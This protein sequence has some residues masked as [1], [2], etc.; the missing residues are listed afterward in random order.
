MIANMCLVLLLATANDITCPPPPPPIDE[1]CLLITTYWVFD[2]NDIAVPF[3]GQADSDPNSTANGTHITPESENQIA[4]IPFDMVGSM[5]YLSNGLVLYGADTFG[6]LER[7]GGL[8][9]SD[10][11]DQW[12]IGV[13]ILTDDYYS[14]L[15]C[16]GEIR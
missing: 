14:Y 8:F 6:D 3:G 11:F 2:E 16:G 9:W 7:Q 12:V 4:A 15:D 13:D 1:A 10:Y 5:V